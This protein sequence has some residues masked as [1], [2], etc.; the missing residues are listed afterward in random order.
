MKIGVYSHSI[1]PSIDGVCR[2]FTGILHE[3]HRQEH[4]LILFTL[5]EDPHDLPP[6]LDWV[7]LDYMFMPAYPTKKVSK[8]N[9]RAFI[10]IFLALAKH[11]P[12][13]V[14]ITNDGV[15]NMFAAAGWLL[16]IPIVGSFHTDL[17]DL[18]VTH[19]AAYFQIF[20]VN[21]KEWVDTRI[22]NSC[23]T[24]S[25]SF[26]RKL[27]KKDIKTEHIIQTAVD[28][29]VFSE[30]KFSAGL[31][32]QMT[33][34]D[35]NAFLCVYVGRISAEKRIDVIIDAIKEL[36][37]VYLAIVGDGPC[38]SMYANMHGKANKI[39]CKPQFLTHK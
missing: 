39:Y 3:L 27:M 25:P 29:D 11:R 37:N 34:G 28:M 2:R 19:N 16:G 26:Q 38:A 31:R 22:L 23:A 17:I 21:M 20:M 36:P 10:K 30:K 33:F 5:E 13:V 15:S 1:A 14:H 9:L 24:T 6:L 12:D 35:P 7:T 4:D 8:P 18:L 32:E